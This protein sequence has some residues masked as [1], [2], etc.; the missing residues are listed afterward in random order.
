M[1]I[2]ELNRSFAAVDMWAAG[3]IFLC[4]LSGSYPFFR[5]PDDVT[6]LAEIMSIFGSHKVKE[7]ALKL[8]EYFTL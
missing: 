7:A 1:F 6:G 4:I 2:T 3:V 8:G 5:A